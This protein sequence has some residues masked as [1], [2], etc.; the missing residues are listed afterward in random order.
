MKRI[1]IKEIIWLTGIFVFAFIAY[2]FISGNSGMD[3]N[4]HDTY[5]VSDGGIQHPSMSFLVFTYFITIGVCIYFV[6]AIYTKFEMILTAII[7]LI[8]AGL[9]LYFL[10]S[11]LFIL[12][13]LISDTPI[14]KY[15][16]HTATPAFSS[17]ISY[18]AIWLPR[19]LRVFLISV[20]AFSGFMIGRKTVTLS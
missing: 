1:I 11:V 15:S 19:I 3:I 14:P 17:H 13:P 7:L 18:M 6:R 20:L 12:R 2:G 5:I 8:M 10:G 4:L 9:C 16:E